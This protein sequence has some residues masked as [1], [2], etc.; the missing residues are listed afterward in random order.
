MLGAVK[1]LDMTQG[2]AGPFCTQLLADMGAEVVKIE[3]PVTGD[4]TR[5]WGPP[6]VG[7]G[8]SAYFFALN[9]NK[10]SV[11]LDLKAPDGR[12]AFEVL[13]ARSDVLVENFRPG[14]MARLG[15]SWEAMKK[16]HRDLIYCSVTGYGQDG[17]SSDET[18]F[19]N[20]IQARSGLMSVTGER[21][22]PP[23]K[24]GVPITDLG[25]GIYASLAIMSA[26][27][28]RTSTGEGAR[29]DVSL[30]DS[31]VSWLVYWLTGYSVKGAELTRTGNAHPTLAP[32]Q[33]FRTVDGSAALGVASD[34]LWEKFAKALG[35]EEL[36]LDP[37]FR[38]NA[39]RV[40]H[41][42]LLVAKV[43]KILETLTTGEL[44]AMMKEAGVPFSGVQSVAALVKD[45]QLIHR[46]M[47]LDMEGVLTPGFPFRI[48]SMDWKLRSPPPALGEDTDR[49][50]GELG[51]SK[52]EIQKLM[53]EADGG[54]PRATRIK[55]G[56]KPSRPGSRRF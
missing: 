39:K 36:L 48:D 24:M 17:P 54:G 53:S 3:P 4:I 23:I 18:A 25:A 40:A 12:K 28:V 16:T 22:G 31:A 2:V 7:E 26:L 10:R 30:L 56:R 34:R 9:R 38:T 29:I 37:R 35:Q 49:V 55:S 20:I 32:Y 41:R 47:I 15:Y 14:V 44:T 42:K 5:S 52:K 1:I 8:R 13:L 46:G 6:F 50:L 43:E 19:D 27:F 33:V 21:D 45:P 51:W 11:V